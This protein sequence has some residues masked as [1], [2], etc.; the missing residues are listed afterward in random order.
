MP[1]WRFIP[2]SECIDLYWSNKNAKFQHSVKKLMTTVFRKVKMD[3]IPHGQR[4]NA[5]RYCKTLNSLHAER[6]EGVCG[7]MLFSCMTTGPSVQPNCQK[8]NFSD[9]VGLFY[10]NHRIVLTWKLLKRYIFGKC[11]HMVDI[12]RQVIQGVYLWTRAPFGQSQQTRC[13]LRRNKNQTSAGSKC[14]M[15]YK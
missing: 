3:L 1:T 13:R 11:F 5:F 8:S 10:H 6:E 2:W 4:V 14:T 9:M 15:F 12:W 7:K